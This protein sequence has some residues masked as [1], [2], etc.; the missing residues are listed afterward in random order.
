[1]APASFGEP[2]ALLAGQAAG[3]DLMLTLERWVQA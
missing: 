2:A 1:M 3:L